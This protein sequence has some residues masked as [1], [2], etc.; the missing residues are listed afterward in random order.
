MRDA[1]DAYAGQFATV[2]DWTYADR[3]A[4]WHGDYRRAYV[5]LVFTTDYAFTECDLD[6]RH[7]KRLRVPWQWDVEARVARCGPGWY[8]VS[9]PYDRHGCPGPGISLRWW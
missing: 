2:Q 5:T 8:V 9:T 1:V 7:C 4:D 3:K 6:G